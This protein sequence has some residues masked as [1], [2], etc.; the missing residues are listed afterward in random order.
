MLIDS[1][2]LKKKTR[3]LI[4]EPMN[5][6]GLPAVNFVSTGPRTNRSDQSHQ[7]DH[8]VRFYVED[9]AFLDAVSRSIGTAL[10]AGNSA[11][12]I[13]TNEHLSGLMQ[14][15]SARGLDIARVAEAGRYIPLRAREVMAKFLSDGLPDA[16]LFEEVVGQVVQRAK[17]AAEVDDRRV[18]V[19][20]E[21]VALLWLE[22]KPAA[23]IRLEQLWNQLIRKYSFSLQCAYPL[24]AFDR[25]EHGEPFLSICGEHL[26][27]IPA[28][29]FTALTGPEE[30]LRN[31]SYLQQKAQAFDSVRAEREQTQKLLHTREAEL[32]DLLENSLEG[33]HQTGPDRRI[34]WA[35]KALL[36]LLGY[37]QEEFVGHDIAEFHVNKQTCDE[38]WNKVMQGE[39]LYDFEAEFRC[40]DETVRHVLIHCNALWDDGRLV[41]TRSFIRDV[42]ERKEM[43]RALKLA[44][45]ELE[46]RVSERTAELMQK[47]IQIMDQSQTLEMTNLGLRR[48]SAH[49]LHVQDEERRRIARELHDSTG[50]SLALLSMNLSSL[51]GKAVTSDPELAEGLSENISIVKQVSTELRTLSYLL[52]PPLLDE[53]GLGSA[54]RW[55][56]DGFGQRSRIK[57]NLELPK[58][59]ERLSRNLE[60]AIFRVV[61]E[62]LT[63]IHLHSGS[64]TATIRLHQSSDKITL[65]IKDE[66]KGIAP[67][68]LSKVNSSGLSG[69][70]LRGMR[71][72]IKDFQGDMEII[73]HEKGTQIKVSVPLGA[74]AS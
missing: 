11:V 41:H 39:D 54:L 59:F 6:A 30:R 34:R 48:L 57:I 70:G 22:G 13:S 74:A 17:S 20:G 63:N 58:E 33:I 19:F 45:E 49:L 12:V 1:N 21:M 62:C 29:D 37:A 44:H 18:F 15:L 2:H 5:P 28:E 69:L 50:Q 9:K 61:Q 51:E 35:N 52:H 66:G 31:V 46:L 3:R 43:E 10:G 24:K 23:A 72:R 65:E 7:R 67:E 25:V 40:K 64:P 36:N 4:G 56:I 26:T 42:T 55:Y 14:R 32:T 73:S 47:N 53:M 8:A 27:V 38:F 68:K 60:T 71:E 16:D